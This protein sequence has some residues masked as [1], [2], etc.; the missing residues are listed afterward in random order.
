MAATAFTDAV[1]IYTSDHGQTMWEDGYRI[2]HC[3]SRHPHPGEGYVP[4][5][6]MTGTDLKSTF[7]S[8]AERGR[9]KA[10]D[11]EIVPTLLWLLG[12]QH[13]WAKERVGDSLLDFDLTRERQ[14]MIGGSAGTND[15]GDGAEWIPVND[16]LLMQHVAQT[17]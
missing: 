1:A 4:L 12:Y 9:H 7:D 5:L 3:S 13:E 2:T 17:Q 11:F 16:T 10:S 14:F 15:W 8:A 6:V